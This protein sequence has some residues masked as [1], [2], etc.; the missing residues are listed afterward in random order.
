MT[1]RFNGA[2]GVRIFLSSNFDIKWFQIAVAHERAALGAREGVMAAPDGSQE[3]GEALDDELQAAMVVVAAAAF[4]LDALY[5]KVD[6]LLDPAERSQ[7][8]SSRA[9]RIAETFKAAFDLGSL[10]GKWQT[11]IPALFDLRDEVVHFRSELHESQPHPTGRSNVSRENTVYTVERATWA[12]D[13]AL[14]VLTTAYRSPRKKHVALSEWA[15]SSAH[16]PTWLE[17]LRH[18]K[19]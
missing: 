14:E 19:P 5:V 1:L 8:K 18:G 7:A 9:G 15:A 11:E 17:E 10:G 6:E 3:V 4:A 13:L 12:V 2:S 16:V